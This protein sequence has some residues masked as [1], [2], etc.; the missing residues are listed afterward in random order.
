[1]SRRLKVL[2]S[3]TAILLAFGMPQFASAQE[4]PA[5]IQVVAIDVDPGE[6]GAY[7]ERLSKAQAIFKRLGLP[8]FRVWLS[9]LSG[10]NT[11]T[12]VIAVEYSDDV[13]RAQNGAKLAADPEWQAWIDGMQKWGKSDVTS[14]SLLVEMTLP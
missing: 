8:T 10:P 11:G 4:A 1:M 14:N 2:L 13:T 6:Q 3:V 12:I 9:S 5:V 7:L